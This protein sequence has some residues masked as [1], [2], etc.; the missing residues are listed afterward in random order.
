LTEDEDILAAEY[1]LG[2][3]DPTEM[4][5]VTARVAEDAAF[6]ARVDWWRDQLCPLVT[7]AETSPS[8]DVWRRIDR[9]LP[10]NDNNRRSLQRWRA[11]AISAMAVAA[12]LVA[13]VIL[14]PLPVTPQPHVML[15][16]L[17]GTG[18]ATATVAY[19]ATSGQLTILPG[20]IDTKGHD[21]ELW[22]IPSDGTPR[23]LGVVDVNHPTH[24]SVPTSR[25]SFIQAGASF[26]ISLEP[27]GGSPTGLPTGPVVSSGK[28]TTT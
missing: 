15:A 19:E 22:I 27:K 16:T 17:Q 14:K 26:A 25:R 1:A 9:A 21:A 8:A 2:L 3:L 7:E 5:L 4:G 20:T 24:P 6:R 18:G 12:S 10:Q 23:S 28:L 11:T 13:V